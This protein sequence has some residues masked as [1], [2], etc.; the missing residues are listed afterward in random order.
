MH[1]GLCDFMRGFKPKWI[2]VRPW[3]KQSNMTIGM[4]DKRHKTK[5]FYA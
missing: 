5:K 4:R 3:E 2:D 1:G